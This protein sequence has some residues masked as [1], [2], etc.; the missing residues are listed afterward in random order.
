MK[1]EREIYNTSKIMIYL[2]NIVSWDAASCVL[3]YSSQTTRHNIP[4]ESTLY[5][6]GSENIKYNNLP[7][8]HSF[9]TVLYE[10][11][12]MSSS[13]IAARVTIVQF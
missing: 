7:L 6:Y 5:R 2:K 11:F 4:E 8:C 1:Y 13:R 12:C 10:F 9:D 3:L